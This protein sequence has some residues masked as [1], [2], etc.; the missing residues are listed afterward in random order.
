MKRY[1]NLNDQLYDGE[2]YFAWFNTVSNLFETHSGEQVW[3][4]WAEFVEAYKGDELPR[5]KALY[6]GR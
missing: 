4:A 2:Y 5:Y 3:G 6:D 1:V